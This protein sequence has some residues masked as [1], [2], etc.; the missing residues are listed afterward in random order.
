M[1]KDK[2]KKVVAQSEFLQTKEEFTKQDI[3][4]L[5]LA[6]KHS[7]DILLELVNAGEAQDNQTKQL[8]EENK[9]LKA[10]LTEHDAKH[11]EFFKKLSA[12]FAETAK[13]C[14]IVSRE[15]KGERT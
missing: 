12:S 6:I 11:S 2:V 15:S 7:T 10:Q 8:I 5:K 13:I 9:K 14:E 4:I 1:L 3:E